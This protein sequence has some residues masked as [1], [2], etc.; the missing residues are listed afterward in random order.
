M[1]DVS[2]GH[3]EDVSGCLAHELEVRIPAGLERLLEGLE[4]KE[5]ATLI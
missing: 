1:Y 3:M 4:G 5:H 2:C